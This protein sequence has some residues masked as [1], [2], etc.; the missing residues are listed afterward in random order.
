[1]KSTLKWKGN[2]T[3]ETQTRNHTLTLD[4]PDHGGKNLG[5]TPKEILLPAIMGCTALDVISW[6]QKYKIEIESFQMESE[7]GTRQTH[8]KV[9]DQVEL[10]YEIKIKNFNREAHL[11]KVLEAVDLSMTKFCGVSAMIASTSPIFY[12]IRV[13]GEIEGRGEAKF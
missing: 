12:T 11:P 1:M 8:P 13:N 10:I 3:L 6:I 2:Y 4:L 5:P 9:F 7:A